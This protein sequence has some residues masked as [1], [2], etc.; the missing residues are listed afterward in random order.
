MTGSNWRI[1]EKKSQF[2]FSRK[3]LL[4]TNYYSNYDFEADMD[5]TRSWYYRKLPFK[6]C[7]ALS[8]VAP[9][10]DYLTCQGGSICTFLTHFFVKGQKTYR[11]DAIE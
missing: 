8:C 5:S 2:K 10:E 4:N 11:N 7:V 9:A 3:A 6:I 1:R